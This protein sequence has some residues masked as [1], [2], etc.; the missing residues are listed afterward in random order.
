MAIIKEHSITIN[1]NFNNQCIKLIPMTNEH[2]PIL[3][4]WNQMP[5]ILYWCEGD[6]VVTNSPDSVKGIYGSISQKA[7]MFIIT[8]DDTPVGDCW[9]QDLNLSELIEKH[10]NKNAKRID[11][12]IYDKSLWNKGMG[13]FVNSIL[14]EFGFMQQNVDLIYAITEDYNER[15]Q[16][17]LLK[18]GFE[19]DEVLEHDET[20]KGK[21]EQCFLI[22][23]EIYML[24]HTE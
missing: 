2:L 10:R 8:I 1:K 11:V 13:R 17:C 4:E 5:D 15:A 16:K 23:K 18:S 20:S 6:D 3:Y 21:S 19:L 7:Y 12:T 9:L 14:L 22:T 24:R